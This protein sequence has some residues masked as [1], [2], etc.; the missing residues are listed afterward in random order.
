MI[1][2]IATICLAASDSAISA[3]SSRTL[4]YGGKLA[5]QNTLGGKCDLTTHCSTGMW[6]GSQGLGIFGTGTCTRN[7][8]MAA[9]EV[10]RD[11]RKLATQ[12]TLGG[13]CDLV[14][15]CV[16]GMYCHGQT[17]GIFGTGNCIHNEAKAAEGV[18]GSVGLSGGFAAVPL[19]VIAFA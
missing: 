7:E 14:T 11:G 3:E 4:S 19:S 2:T 6:C 15:H 8:G 18:L 1:A 16:S 5:T 17:I 12:N 9:P 10:F 13:K